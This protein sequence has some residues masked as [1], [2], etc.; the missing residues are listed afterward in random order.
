MTRTATRR[1]GPFG[2]L[3]VFIA[4][5]AGCHKAD[6]KK[7]EKDR[8]PIP[9][10]TAKAEKRTLRPTFEVIGT[11]L[12]DPER[13]ATLTAATPGLVD[14]L[15]VSEGAKVKKT[16]VV[17]RLDD[18][19][20]KTDLDR[21]ESAYARL[22]AKPRPDELIVAQGA[23]EKAKAAHAVAKAQI[24]KAKE[25]R[26]TN[27]TLV[28]EVQLL[29]YERAERIAATDVED[30]QAHFRLLE[31]G[32]REELRREARV[33]VE[34]TKLQLE[35]CKVT[36]P[37]DGEVVALLAQ[38][39]M[40]ADVGTP[41]ARVLDT[42]EVLV[43]ARVPGNRMSGVLAV[44]TAPGKDP[45]AL[46]TSLSFP[47]EV[48]AAK[49]GWLNQ[50][51]EA[52]TGDV[53]VKLRVPNPK[54]LLRVGMSVR[55]DLSEPGVEGVAIPEAALTVNEEGHHVVTVI[56]DGKAVPTEI[57]VDSETELEV[58]ADGWVRVLKGI[59]EGD[60]VA[61]ENGYALPKDTP[62]QILPPK[63]PEVA[64]P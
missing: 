42:R 37:I 12:A 17:V 25:T 44:V 51:T 4:L 60:E 28:T 45:P 18:R 39:G 29:E 46:I 5:L 3:L 49:S 35:F 22:I 63:P 52:M 9:V 23:V 54:G 40:K 11:V 13:V 53:P 2:T 8:P 6:E 27:P 19:K 47:G 21:A 43:Q 24:D 58:R 26:R 55:V 1:G 15:P 50:Q 10:R 38:V 56:K 16:D 41:V 14:A 34:A 36:S 59:S 32:P 64:H 62:V 61:V 31:L 7:A 20:A 57:E 33:E 30:A 48:F